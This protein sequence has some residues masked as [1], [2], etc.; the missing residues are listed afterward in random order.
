MKKSYL[1]SNTTISINEKH[2]KGF[3]ECRKLFLYFVLIFQFLVTI[4]NAQTEKQIAFEQMLAGWSA[5]FVDK[6]PPDYSDT[7]NFHLKDDNLFTHIVFTDGKFRI[8]NGKAKNARI[9]M[10][11]SLET[12]HKVY[13]G[14]LSPITAAGRA[15]IRERAPLDFIL[16]G[17]MT[18]R[19][20]DW[21]YAYFTLINF[22]NR[23]P[24]NKV[25]LGREHTRTVHGGNTAGL[26]YS[27]GFRSAYYHIA[28]D[29]VLNEAGEKD[30]WNQSFIIISGCGFAKIGNDTIAV[31]ANEAY[32]IRPKLEHKVW[33]QC[34]EG[35]SLI[36]NAWGIEAW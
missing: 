19:N 32:Y 21:N 31:K 23:H 36:W 17:G 33:T 7:L 4:S 11:A 26:Y 25:L 8:E 3:G 18:P 16:E 14:E 24:H 13:S 15:S 20:M 27:P 28:K 1:Q 29:Q 34:D 35:I 5:A 9:I 22:F 12:Y 6:V 10:T 30:P 2:L